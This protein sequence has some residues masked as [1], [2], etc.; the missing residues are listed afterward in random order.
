MNSHLE[1]IQ[2][3]FKNNPE[4]NS[5]S[6]TYLNT[7]IGYWVNNE[8]NCEKFHE[9]VCSMPERWLVVN[10]DNYASSWSVADCFILN[11]PDN[12]ISLSSEQLYS[13]FKKIDLNQ[14]CKIS[15]RMYAAEII[16]NN[17]NLKLNKTH[18][19]NLLSTCDFTTVT[20]NS[21][22]FD[23]AT[24]MSYVNPRSIGLS[25]EE[26]CA[27]HQ[28]VCKDKQE[29]LVSCGIFYIM[30]P[31]STHK[32]IK[33]VD[34]FIDLAQNEEPIR[35]K[36]EDTILPNLGNFS[37]KTNIIFEQLSLFKLGSGLPKRKIGL[38]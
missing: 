38:L 21:T 34:Q 20:E 6:K 11:A 8:L 4:I 7:L 22:Q 10:S 5:E 18:L 28:R 29:H 1:T 26:F 2:G 27:F 13:I 32:T 24:A 12:K 31:R 37:R 14:F 3:Y 36:M 17:D 23:L 19:L 15:E 30:N 33:E 16:Y 35:R 9:I 25:F